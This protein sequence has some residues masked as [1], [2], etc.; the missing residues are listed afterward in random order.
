MIKKSIKI[1]KKSEFPAEFRI[2]DRYTT[3]N[4]VIANVL[5]AISL[6]LVE[7]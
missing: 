4:K 6:T 3:E 1:N 5:T 2:D 7:T